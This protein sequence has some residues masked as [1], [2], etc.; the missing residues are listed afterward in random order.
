ML[1]GEIVFWAS[2]ALIAYAYVGYPLAL[3]VISLARTRRVEKA[4]ISP[5]VTFIITAHNEEKRI[6]DK[7][8]NTLK[9]AYPHSKLEILVASDCS[10]DRTDE[11]VKS[12]GDRGIQLVRASVRKGKEAAQSLAVAVAKGEILVFSDVATI[13]PE[14][15]MSNI[16]KNFH[17]RT[18]GCVSS[19]DRF[20]DQHGR[21]SGEGGYV[22][23][24]MYLRALE[25]RVNS[26][27]GLSGS[28]FAARREVCQDWRE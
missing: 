20:V 13:L 19:V 23:Y 16:V 17:D 7:L 10:T 3:G 27:V 22:K 11:I 28:F 4:D 14:R 12:Y 21:A 18:V 24:E 8:E 26:L 25:T 9:L 1:L 2:V 15:A 5:S 6:A